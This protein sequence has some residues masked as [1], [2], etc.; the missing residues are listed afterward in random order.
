MKLPSWFFGFFCIFALAAFVILLP[1][2]Y[3]PLVTH[4]MFFLKGKKSITC[5]FLYDRMDFVFLSCILYILL[6]FIEILGI[7]DILGEGVVLNT[8][9]KLSFN[10]F[11]N[12]FHCKIPKLLLN[13]IVAVYLSPFGVSNSC[14]CIFSKFLLPVSLIMELFSSVLSLSFL[15]M[16]W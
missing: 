1:V 4:I 3:I 8:T 14:F 10:K 6:F 7:F 13:R 16:K 11:F 12:D 5:K 2:L 15:W 9:L